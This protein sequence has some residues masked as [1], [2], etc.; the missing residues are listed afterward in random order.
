MFSGMISVLDPDSVLSG[1][2]DKFLA[3]LVAAVSGTR[4]PAD[5]EDLGTTDAL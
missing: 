2:G 4:N 1:L 5:G 3:A